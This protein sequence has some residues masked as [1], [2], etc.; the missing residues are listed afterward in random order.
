[1]NSHTNQTRPTRSV[2]R[3]AFLGGAAMAT[4]PALLP[5]MTLARPGLIA[6]T[7]VSVYLRGAMDGL[8][9]CVPYGDTDLYTARPTLAIQPPGQPDGAIDLDGFFGLAPAAAPLLGPYQSGDLLF[10]HASGSPDPS[11]SHFDAQRFM[12]TATPLQPTSSVTT[13]WIGRYLQG[14]PSIG[15]GAFRAMGVGAR[16][17]KTLNGGPGTL[18][19]ADPANFNFPG[20]LA[21]AALR[22]TAIEQMYDR[23]RDPL[24]SAADNTLA[25]I[26]LLAGVDFAGYIPDNGATYPATPFGDQLKN[27]AAVIKS[28]IGLE[29][30]HLDLNG[31][32]HH[33]AMGPV[34][35]VL[36]GLLDELSRALE[37]FHLDMQLYWGRMVLVCMTEFGRRIRENGSAGTDHGHGGCMMVMG[38]HIAG[39]QVYTNPWPGLDTSTGSGDLEVTT[40]Y[41]DI[42]AEILDERM[43]A[44]HLSEIFPNYVPV[45][46]GIVN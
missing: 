7:L 19:I 46:R 23:T 33:S 3:R 29:T 8:T 9:L 18:P 43:G 11:R 36:A 15:N 2:S 13:G 10:V 26:D 44:T 20:N 45:Y 16:L 30:I 4:T 25:S 39:G 32:D 17:P 31:W 40:D 35:G 6:D 5:R 41:R 21:T 22:R 14:A 1:M 24:A 27:T 38:G 37:A 42:L 34:N 12:E 28:G